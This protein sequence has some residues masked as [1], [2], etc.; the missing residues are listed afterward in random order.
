MNTIIHIIEPML[1]SSQAH[2]MI[3]AKKKKKNDKDLKFKIGDHVRI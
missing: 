2:V 3:L 1:M